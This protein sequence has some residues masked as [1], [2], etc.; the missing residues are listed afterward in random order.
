MVTLSEKKKVFFY[1]FIIFICN[2]SRSKK[3][4][5]GYYHVHCT[6]IQL[7][8]SLI[9]VSNFFTFR[10]PC[11]A[12]ADAGVETDTSKVTST[13]SDALTPIFYSLFCEGNFVN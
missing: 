9:L 12:V 13:K 4:A 1:F 6:I 5:V 3:N 8:R 11:R 7:A 10:R 2:I